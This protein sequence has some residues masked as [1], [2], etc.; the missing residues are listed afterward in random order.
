VRRNDGSI[1]ILHTLNGTAVSL[2]RALM[3]LIENCQDGDKLQVPEVL[4][5][6]LGNQKTL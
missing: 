4:Q 5:K 2:T 1:E 3:A 6:Y